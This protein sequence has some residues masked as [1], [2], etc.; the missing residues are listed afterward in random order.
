MKSGIVS[1]T[2]AIYTGDHSLVCGVLDSLN[3]NLNPTPS[4]CLDYNFMRYTFRDKNSCRYLFLIEI[5]H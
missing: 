3:E 1:K 2:N 4:N 5:S